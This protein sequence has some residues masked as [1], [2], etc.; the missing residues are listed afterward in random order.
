MSWADTAKIYTNFHNIHFY[1][2]PFPLVI[3]LD[4]GEGNG[5]LDQNNLTDNGAYQLLVLPLP[6]T[7]NTLPTTIIHQPLFQCSSQPFFLSQCYRISNKYESLYLLMKTNCIFTIFQ[8]F[9]PCSTHEGTSC[10]QRAVSI[11]L[12]FVFLLVKS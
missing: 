2:F 7:P 12:L 9:F 4:W 8:I 1:L 10:S 11:N 6:I 5:R 3:I